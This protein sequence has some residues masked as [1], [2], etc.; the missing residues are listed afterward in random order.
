V[1]VGGRGAPRVAVVLQLAV[2]N[3]GKKS[4]EAEVQ[5]GEKG[6]PSMLARGTSSSSAMN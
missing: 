1:Q 5:N 3:S 2:T 4:M 6:R